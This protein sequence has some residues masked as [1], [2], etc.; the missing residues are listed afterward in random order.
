MRLL[1][2]MSDWKQKLK[3]SVTLTAE[4]VRVLLGCFLMLFVSQKCGDDNCSLDE[5][6]DT[7]NI[8]RDVFWALHLLSAISVLFAYW[9][10]GRREKWLIDHFDSNPAKPDE[11]MVADWDRNKQLH[12]EFRFRTRFLQ[13]VVGGSFLIY[14]VNWV[15]TSIYLIVWYWNGVSTATGLLTQGVL[16]VQALYSTYDAATQSLKRNVPISTVLV[17]PTVF[18]QWDE[19]LKEVFAVEVSV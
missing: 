8:A 7:S 3:S 12:I 1:E 15:G 10:E 19:D 11:A 6:R 13:L 9:L 5:I 18:N 14:I 16:V 17:E 4:G 2:E